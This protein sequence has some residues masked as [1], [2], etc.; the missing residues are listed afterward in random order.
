MGFSRPWNNITSH[1][2]WTYVPFVILC[3][4]LFAIEQIRLQSLEKGVDHPTLTTNHVIIK[5]VLLLIVV[6]YSTIDIRYGFLVFVIVITYLQRNG[7]LEE[8]KS[9]RV[10]QQEQTT[11]NDEID[12][13][14]ALLA[15]RNRK[16]PRVKT[17][18]PK[19]IIQTGPNRMN[20]KYKAYMEALQA[21]N[22]SFQHLYFNDDDI[23]TFFKKFY[24][25]YWPT[26]QKLPVFIQKIDFFR[27]VAVYHYGGFYFD[28]DVKSLAPIDDKLCKHA[29][30]FPVDEYIFKGFCHHVR[31]E[32]FCKRG[33]PFLLG[34]YA[35][36]AV[37]KHPFL[38]LLMDTIHRKLD[39]YVLN[40]DNTELYVYRSTGPDFVTNMY[41]D[42]Y[43]RDDVF[44]LDN[45][46]RQYFGNYGRH[47][48]FGSWK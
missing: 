34:Q 45:G 4:L 14:S 5:T 9:T 24:P 15:K 16:E 13:I 1:D 6:Y 32:S 20:P 28:M 19:I 12:A 26:Y 18:I 39:E 36:A 31:Y 17:A 43:A 2:W 41:L 46:K 35:F 23:E 21:H 42:E 33:A 3:G 27:Y 11:S 37:P 30:V 10:K 29:C 7:L 40:A 38:K 48:F 44:I 47:D 25:Q 22:P 8:I